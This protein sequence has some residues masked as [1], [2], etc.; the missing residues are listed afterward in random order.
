MLEK[1]KSKQGIFASIN[2]W[3][4]SYSFV[5]N[6]PG[7]A[8]ALVMIPLLLISACATDRP[9]DEEG[10]ESSAAEIHQTADEYS[11]PHDAFEVT[12]LLI[13]QAVPDL[14][15]SDPAVFIT[16]PEGT[17]QFKYVNPNYR[18]RI[19]GEILLTALQVYSE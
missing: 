7:G 3:S 4:G 12:P 15:V 17:I 10:P 6:L 18:E 2:L 16:D 8:L 19:S 14:P 13:G 1:L 11:V 5:R 9:G